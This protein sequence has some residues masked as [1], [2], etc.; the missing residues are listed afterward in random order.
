MPCDL[1]RIRRTD[2]NE[3]ERCFD[4]RAVGDTH[5]RAIDRERGV[6]PSERRRYVAVVARQ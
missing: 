3:M 1:V 6:Q 4:V 5:K 2:E